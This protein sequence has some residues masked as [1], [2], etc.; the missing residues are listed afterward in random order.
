M[1]DHAVLEVNEKSYSCTRRL[2]HALQKSFTGV[3]A[4]LQEELCI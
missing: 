1:R 2:Q 3:I 4:K